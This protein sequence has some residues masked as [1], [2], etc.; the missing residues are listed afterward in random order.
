MGRLNHAIT[1]LNILGSLMQAVPVIGDSLKSATEIATLICETVEVRIC[2]S[3][4]TLARY[5]LQRIKENREGYEQLAG[6][7]TRLLEAVAS[8]IT[9]A[10]PENLKGLDEYMARLV[11]W[12]LN[13]C[14][15]SECPDFV[16]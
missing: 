16:N 4:H 8:T 15:L 11:L 6:R 7:T 12:V 10:D 9:K 14:A 2:C 5:H 13:P 1:A 3:H